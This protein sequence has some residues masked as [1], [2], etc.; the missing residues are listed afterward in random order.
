MSEYVLTCEST[1]DHPASFFSEREI[2]FV[3]FHYDLDGEV[4]T[5]DLYTTITPKAFF[6]RLKA[7]ARSTTSQPSA[8]DYASFWESLL[9][10]GR[11]VVHVTLSSGIS[12]AYNA[13]C[14]AAEQAASRFPGRVVHVVDSLAASSGYGMLMEYAA[15]L[16]DRGM[17]AEELCR[18]ICEHRLNLNHW[19]FVSD[20]ECLK[21]GGRVS[22]T[23]ALL[24]SKL[25]ICPVLNVD[26]KGGLTARQKI[27]TMPRAELELVHMMETHAE[28]RA[29]Y[30]GKCCLC[31]SN[32]LRHAETVRELVEHRFPQLAG[33]VQIHDIGTVIGSHT[34]PGT[35][36][37]FFMGDARTD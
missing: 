13:A 4:M 36:G 8:G 11:D 19:F 18:W 32:C 17:D 33:K 14:V 9:A 30:D 5:D 29:A 12:G 7:G 1:A 26:C 35:V 20:L 28:G 16:R 24:A 27:R 22:A 3:C 31:H 25:K 15:D 34:G 37:L 6:D 2:P 21:R 10:A 23:S